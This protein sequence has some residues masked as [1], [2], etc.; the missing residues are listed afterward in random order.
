MPSWSQKIEERTIPA[1][2]Y[3]RNFFGAG[4]VAMPPFHWLLLCLRV[5]VTK[6][7]FVHGHQSRPTVNNLD[8]AEKIPNLLRRLTLFTFMIRVHSFRD[9]LRVELPLV[10]IFKNDA[11]LLNYL[12][13]RCPAVHVTGHGI[14]PSQ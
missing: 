9:A 14:S 8:R 1:D 3:T 12:F 10:Q 6:P 5:I 7:S 13:S 4:W 11:L 2:F